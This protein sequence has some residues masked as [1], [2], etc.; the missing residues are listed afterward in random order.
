MKNKL[1]IGLFSFFVCFVLVACQSEKNKKIAEIKAIEKSLFTNSGST[2]DIAL[3]EK[4]TGLYTE[5]ATRFPDDS[6]AIE[7][8]FK[9][10][11]VTNGIGKPEQAF[12]MFGSLFA[13]YPASQKAPLALFMQGFIAETRLFDKEKAKTIYTDFLLKYPDH[14]LSKDVRFSLDNLDKTDEELIRQFEEMNADEEDP[15]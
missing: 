8:L 4:L 2:P 14:N 1:R 3:A 5:Y 9:A 12:E 13:M 7:Y 10:A 15:S 11:E 6:L